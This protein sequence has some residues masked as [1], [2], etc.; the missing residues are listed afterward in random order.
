MKLNKLHLTCLSI[1]LLA[2][3]ACNKGDQDFL[4]KDELFSISLSG[5]NAG[6]EELIVKLGTITFPTSLMPNSSFNHTNAYT[7]GSAE[8]QIKLSISEKTS[9]KLV[10]ERELK[11]EDRTVK[12]NFLYID[13]RISPMPEKPPVEE[14]KLK[15]L[16]MFQP[17][18]SNYTEP[19]DF[20]VGKYYSTPKVFEE[21]ARAKNVKPYEFG[22]AITLPTFST[23]RQEYN[24]VMTAVSFVVRICKAGTN[25][26]YTD[27]T[28]Y[29]WNPLSSTA[30]KPA[31]SNPSSKLY[32]FS[33]APVGDIMRFFTRLDQ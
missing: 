3:T 5:Y 18:V 20:V 6:D 22:P 26:P 9:G 30:P 15:L 29:T 2:L 13:G 19:V 11:K 8:N 4:Y 31:A 14:G 1:M 28:A 33:E 12:E 23:A 24:G 7:F 16:Y 25:I 10:L 32:I 27:G 17:S 21:V